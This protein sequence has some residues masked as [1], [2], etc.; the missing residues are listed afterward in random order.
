MITGLEAGTGLVGR[1]QDAGLS[2]TEN[3]KTQPEIRQRVEVAA[4]V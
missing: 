3:P 2:P 1:D 4:K